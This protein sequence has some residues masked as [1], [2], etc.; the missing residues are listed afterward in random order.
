MTRQET[1]KSFLEYLRYEKNSSPNT[2]LAYKTDIAQFFEFIDVEQI[3]WQAIDVKT[4]YAF[5][6]HI[7]NHNGKEIIR[8]SQARK[9][10]AIKS[11]YR[12]SEKMGYLEINPI[13]KMRVPAGRRPLPKPL[14]P[15]E[16]ETML[17]NNSGQNFWIQARDKALMELMYSSGMRI[18]EILNL[19]IAHI[20]SSTGDISGSIVISGKGGKQ[21]VVFIGNLAKTSL[22]NYLSLRSDLKKNEWV[23][24]EAPL[25]TNYHGARI[26]RKGAAYVLKKRRLNLI[27]D[28]KITPHALRHSFAT[29]LLNSGADIRVVQEMMGHSSISTTQNYTKVAREKL[30]NTFRSCHPHAKKD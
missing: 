16:M 29:D 17:E 13:G 11:F 19:N 9:A 26:T 15:G 21:R 8:S 5:L 24:S 25:F 12:Y 18:S 14:R 28:E 20:F 7:L 4:I 22:N 2:L 6:G 3:L 1:E 23:M 30:Q 10:A 27:G